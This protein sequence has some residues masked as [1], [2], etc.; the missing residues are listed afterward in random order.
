MP[1]ASK[2]LSKIDDKPANIIQYLE[3]IGFNLKSREMLQH[4][5][6]NYIIQNVA[7]KNEKNKYAKIW[8]IFKYSNQEKIIYFEH[9]Q[10][11]NL[12]NYIQ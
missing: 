10:L 5:H 2:K 11:S 8:Q 7:K 1:R 12:K 4:R 3:S 9:K 6:T